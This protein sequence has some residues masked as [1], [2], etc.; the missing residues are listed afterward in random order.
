MP[1]FACRLEAF[2]GEVAEGKVIEVRIITQVRLL[3]KDIYPRPRK[4]GCSALAVRFAVRLHAHRVE[5]LSSSCPSS[6]VEWR[7]GVNHTLV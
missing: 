7:G 4:Y 1:L 2:D 3:G 6:Y 5:E